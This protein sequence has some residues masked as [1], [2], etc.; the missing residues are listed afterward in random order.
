MFDIFF[1]NIVNRSMYVL[2][3]NFFSDEYLIISATEDLKTSTLGG[4]L[5]EMGVYIK[6]LIM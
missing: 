1:I 4:F 5:G 6:N 3:F 2:T